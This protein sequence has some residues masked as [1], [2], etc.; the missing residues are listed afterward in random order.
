M[1]LCLQ[2]ERQILLK[3][4][5]TNSRIVRM[6][7]PRKRPKFPPK[8]AERTNT[9]KKKQ[10]NDALK[11]FDSVQFRFNFQLHSTFAQ[12][13]RLSV[14]QS[15]KLSFYFLVRLFVIKYILVTLV[16]VC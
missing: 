13:V 1:L 10:V 5:S 6:L 14:T 9:K 11:D 12:A 15:F 4:N 3:T 16:T 2:I 8:F 7:I